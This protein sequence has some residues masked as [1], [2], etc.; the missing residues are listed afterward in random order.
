MEMLIASPDLKRKFRLSLVAQVTQALRSD[1]KTIPERHNTS[2]MACR[3]TTSFNRGEI[4]EEI[5]R[6]RAELL[7]FTRN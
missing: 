6:K 4:E 5:L 1:K 7:V 2:K 3:C